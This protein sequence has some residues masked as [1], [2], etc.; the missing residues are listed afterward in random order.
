MEFNDSANTILNFLN[1]KKDDIFYD[2]NEAFAKH[3]TKP[4]LTQ[5][6]IILEELRLYIDIQE[7]V[8]GVQN[9]IK[10]KIKFE[11]RK[12]IEDRQ[13]KSD[14]ISIRRKDIIVRKWALL[15]GAIPLL[16]FLLIRFYGDKHKLKILE[17]TS[18]NQCL[19]LIVK[20]EDSDPR[21]IKK[22]RIRL[23]TRDSL[24]GLVSPQFSQ[25]KD[26]EIIN[27]E[28]SKSNDYEINPRIFVDKVNIETLR[29]NFHHNEALP[30]REFIKMQ[31]EI[32]DDYGNRVKSD[33]FYH[34]IGQTKPVMYYDSITQKYWHQYNDM[35][36]EQIAK[37][38]LFRTEPVNNVIKFY[39]ERSG[40]LI[41]LR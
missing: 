9:P 22:I 16:I 7:A 17:I 30:E 10:A 24:F 2:V 13:K 39:K 18:E 20:N 27:V 40:N 3:K 8:I 38:S 36:I 26:N 35:V 37:S 1:K 19:K 21:Y 11:G 4:T 15:I 29:F 28:L 14:E 5:L 6:K 34:F 33:T 41:F 32:S 23:F 31:V 12:F 25:P